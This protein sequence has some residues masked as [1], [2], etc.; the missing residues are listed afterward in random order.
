LQ[1]YF[2]AATKRRATANYA[3]GTR[4]SFF[5]I[6]QIWHSAF[7]LP[8]GSD[9]ISLTLSFCYHK[10]RMQMTFAG[11]SFPGRPYRCHTHECGMDEGEGGKAMEQ[12]CK[13]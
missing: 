7:I 10:T 12:T 8:F 5:S 4:L 13:R 9:F 3:A 6:A 11:G 2:Q 1:A